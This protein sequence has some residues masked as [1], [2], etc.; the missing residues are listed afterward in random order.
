MLTGDDDF[1]IGH[2]VSL[3]RLDYRR[4]F[5]G[6][7]PSTKNCEYAERLLRHES[8]PWLFGQVFS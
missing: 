8:P 2:G 7:R 3:Q 6:F 5:D 1:D 4:H